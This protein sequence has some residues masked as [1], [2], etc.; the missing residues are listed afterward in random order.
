M[1][2]FVLTLF[3]AVVAFG[4]YE[5][6][7]IGP[8]QPSKGNVQIPIWPKA[9]PGGQVV[10]GPEGSGLTK[11][12]GHVA[13]KSWNWVHDVVKPTMTIYS[14]KGKNTKAAGTQSQGP[15]ERGLVNLGGLSAYTG[16]RPPTHQG[17]LAP[18]QT[19]TPE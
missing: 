3:F 1:K 2:I 6:E 11:K 12:S 8:W 17:I 16:Y 7:E 5:D 9:A 14:P 13:G 18:N 15:L 4:A 19:H 10:K